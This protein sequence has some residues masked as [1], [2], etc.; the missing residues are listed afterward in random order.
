MKSLFPILL[1][2][3][4]GTGLWASGPDPTEAAVQAAAVSSIPEFLERIPV[5]AEVRFG[6]A[7]RGEFQRAT[8]GRPY[9]MC[10]LVA[11]VRDAANPRCEYEARPLPEW[12]VPILVDGQA[13]ALLTMAPAA[14]GWQAVDLGAAGLARELARQE[15]ATGPVSGRRFILRLFD[16]HVDFLVVAR[17]TEIS[18]YDTTVPLF[19][20]GAALG[21]A[22]GAKPLSFDQLRQAV[23]QRR[24]S[25]E[26]RTQ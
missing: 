1:I 3:A 8:A 10:T 18:S 12:R 5:G 16:L 7:E 22:D 21:L 2:L 17:T 6:F 24:M 14:G 23:Q 25:V 13:R 20:A 11:S 9:R 4:I 19:S 26:E 15:P